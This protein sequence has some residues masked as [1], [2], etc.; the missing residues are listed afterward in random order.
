MFTGPYFEAS[1]PRKSEAVADAG[2][3][4]FANRTA[5]NSLCENGQVT[6]YILAMGSSD[7]F[8]SP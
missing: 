4:I 7:I 3:T 2:K 6:P 5:Y 8:V 1:A